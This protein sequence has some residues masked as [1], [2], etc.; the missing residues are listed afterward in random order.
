[1]DEEFKE[2]KELL[3]EMG[4]TEEEVAKILVRLAEY[5][6]EMQLDSIM[7]SIGNGRF[8][9]SELIKEALED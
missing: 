9:F 7:D 8:N 1:M 5:E 4:H 6:K 3:A 2:V